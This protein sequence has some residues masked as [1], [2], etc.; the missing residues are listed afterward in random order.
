[1]KKIL[2]AG[3]ALAV[4]AV[5]TAS[6]ADLPSRRTAPPAYI[7]PVFTWTGFYVGLNA[8]Y[9][10]NGDNKLKNLNFNG[11]YPDSFGATD[12]SDDG[13]FTGGGQIGYNYQM[14]SF[15]IGLE[16]DFNYIDLKREST[17]YNYTA[18]GLAYDEL[19]GQNKVEWFGTVRPR[20]GFTPVDR[21]LVFVT[22][23][24]A[25]GSVKTS[26]AYS[27]FAT[28]YTLSGSKSDTRVGWTVGAGLEYAITDN[29]TVKG[30]Y[31]YVDLGDKRRIWTDINANQLSTKESTDFHVV[32]AGVNYKF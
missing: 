23:G 15:V 20:V 4:L 13:S 16:A 29:F 7:P 11:Y 10:F 8:G 6:A 21:L 14:G 28:G 17:S 27:D 9:A 22:G 2:L 3:A 32:R 1:M 24:L 31:A 19:R 12:K 18:A 30:E 26:A 25:Y 5:G